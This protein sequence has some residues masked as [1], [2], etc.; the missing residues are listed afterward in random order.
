MSQFSGGLSVSSTSV[1]S[2][3][4][5]KEGDS[6]VWTGP[7][8]VRVPSSGPACELSYVTTMP[9]GVAP[10]GP[11]VGEEGS[12]VSEPPSTEKPLT[13]LAP[14]STIQ[15]V[16]LSGESRASSGTR[17]VGLLSVVLPSSVSVPSAAIE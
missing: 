2:V 5:G 14:A 10:A 4:V 12:S 1:S 9:E 15:S 17:P 16:E 11:G 13:A 6:A 8:G 3:S 7:E